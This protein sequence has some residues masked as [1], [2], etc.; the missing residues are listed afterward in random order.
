[1]IFA[2]FDTVQMVGFEVEVL[3]GENWFVIYGYF[4]RTLCT[5]Y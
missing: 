5:S 4:E 1:M 2:F 3:S